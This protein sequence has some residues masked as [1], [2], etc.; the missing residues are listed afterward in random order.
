MIDYDRISKWEVLLL[1]NFHKKNSFSFFPFWNFFAFFFMWKNA[2]IQGEKKIFSKS[3]KEKL[4]NLENQERPTKY[5]NVFQN[6]DNSEPWSFSENSMKK[7]VSNFFPQ[8]V[9]RSG[10]L[11]PRWRKKRFSY[12]QRCRKLFL[13]PLNCRKL[14]PQIV[15]KFFFSLFS[16]FLKFLL[17]KS[18]NVRPF[19]EKGSQLKYCWSVGGQ[20]FWCCQTFFQTETDILEIEISRALNSLRLHC[21]TQLIFWGN[22]STIV[23]SKKPANFLNN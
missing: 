7:K 5:G 15:S 13:T 6:P 17:E 11:F 1:K 2:K 10:N 8:E 9:R 18:L 4:G 21:A 19:F 14:N 12:Q 20:S 22:F 3:L 23:S 16:I